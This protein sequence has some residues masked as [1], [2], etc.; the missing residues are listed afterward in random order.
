MVILKFLE[1][2]C[3]FQP[4]CLLSILILEHTHH[5][6]NTKCLHKSKAY[7]KYRRD[8]VT[9]SIFCHDLG[10][11]HLFQRIF[12]YKIK[13]MNYLGDRIPLSARHA[14]SESHHQFSVQPTDK[15]KSILHNTRPSVLCLI[16]LLFID[17]Q[18]ANPQATQVNFPITA[19]LLKHESQWL[20]V[21]AHAIS[22]KISSTHTTSSTQRM[23]PHQKFFRKLKTDR[24]HKHDN[25]EL[26]CPTE[27]W[28]K[29]HLHPCQWGCACLQSNLIHL[30]FDGICGIF[31]G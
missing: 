10:P 29:H 21:K 28:N 20:P 19:S 23:R 11:S 9:G 5:G 2:L 22:R 16:F 7:S 4:R 12:K 25:Q 14:D 6:N 15:I 18:S 27:A 8:R 24:G 17:N 3:D 26:L 31:H 30:Y 13:S 1:L